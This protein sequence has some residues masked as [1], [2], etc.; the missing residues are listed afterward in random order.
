M[1]G[2]GTRSQIKWTYEPCELQLL[3]MRELLRMVKATLNWTVSSWKGL[4]FSSTCDTG[5]PTRL[6]KDSDQ[7][8]LV[9]SI[10]VLKGTIEAAH[11]HEID[12]W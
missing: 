4:Y 9:V 11:Q 1:A 2:T 8:D 10:P 7:P 6:L 5:L 3:M 12:C